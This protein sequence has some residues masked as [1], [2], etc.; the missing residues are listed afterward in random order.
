[1]TINY[2]FPN[3]NGGAIEVRE[4]ISNFISFYWTYD[5]VSMLGLKLIHVSK[6]SQGFLQPRTHLEGP[7]IRTNTG[8]NG[9]VSTSTVE[10]WNCR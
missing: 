6:M 2:P 7:W 3:F 9:I 10:P 1:M 5:Y 8:A 4:R